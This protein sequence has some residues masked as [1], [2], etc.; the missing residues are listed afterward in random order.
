MTITAEQL[1]RLRELAEKATR[2]EWVECHDDEGTSISCRGKQIAR[3][4]Y[5]RNPHD[6]EDGKFIAAAS[7][8]VVLALLDRIAELEANAVR[9]RE[10]RF[11]LEGIATD[12]NGNPIDVTRQ[13]G[14]PTERGGGR[15]GK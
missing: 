8:D 1:A 3:S 13:V 2:G 12:G 10:Y 11:A 4:S 5:K 6:H 14:T 7:P 15:E 9:M